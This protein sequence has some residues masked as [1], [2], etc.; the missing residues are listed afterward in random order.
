MTKPDHWLPFR[1]QLGGQAG[2]HAREI[3]PGEAD[4]HLD[5][6]HQRG[7]AQRLAR[8][9]RRGAMD[10]LTQFCAFPG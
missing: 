5:H 8:P 1:L 2:R 9:D 3:P 6:R 4:A 10:H 7:G